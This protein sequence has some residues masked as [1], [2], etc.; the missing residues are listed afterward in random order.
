MSPLKQL[1][2]PHDSLEENLFPEATANAESLWGRRGKR[3]PVDLGLLLA[4]ERGTARAVGDLRPPLPSQWPRACSV[5]TM[6]H[7]GASRHASERGLPQGPTPSPPPLR[8]LP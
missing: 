4:G 2:H 1:S 5:P 7:E 8:C 6:P 3:R